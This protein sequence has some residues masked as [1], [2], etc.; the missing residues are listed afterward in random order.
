MTEPIRVTTIKPVDVHDVQDQGCKALIMLAVSLGW[1]AAKS[2][3]PMHLVSPDDGALVRVPTNTSIRMSLWRSCLQSIVRHSSSHQATEELIE[4]IGKASKMSKSHLSRMKALVLFQPD[5][6]EVEFN[7]EPPKEDT[8]VSINLDVIKAEQR[9]RTLV[10]VEPYIV[11]LGA[12]ATGGNRNYVSPNV[13]VWTWSDGDQTLHCKFCD[14][15]FSTA[16]GV[17]NHAGQK[18][19]GLATEGSFDNGGV[20]TPTVLTPTPYK[21]HEKKEEPPV[22]EPEPEPITDEEWVP[23]AKAVG[24][25]PEPEPDP[26]EIALRLLQQ[27]RDLLW[28]GIDQYVE[29]L[30]DD[31]KTARQERDAAVA[32]AEKAEQY[33]Q[34]LRELLNEQ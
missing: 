15:H 28:P 9:E 4:A 22:V 6:A 26:D 2:P 31:A 34:T 13:M 32:R 29:G 8:T 16:V 5:E 25:E 19:R 1:S 24:I 3:G 30:L 14:M 7:V 27:I 17:A 18:H 10:K 21:S 20:L 12:R 11:R 23:F 33:I